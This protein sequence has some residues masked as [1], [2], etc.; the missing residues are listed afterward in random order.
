M[1][2]QRINIRDVDEKA[3][4]AVG[5]LSM[6]LSKG[7]LGEAL[8]AMIEIRAS[9]I[10]NCAWCLDMHTEQ[11]RNA[12]VDQRKLDLL[13]AW[14]EAPAVFTPREQAAMALTEQ[15]TLIAD[16]GVSD[17][18]WDLVSAEFDEKEIVELIM[19]IATIN[20]Y[21]R[22]NVTAHTTVGTERFVPNW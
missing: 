4:K 10:N 22:M 12:G 9:Q 20:V 11:A 2:E 21:N 7:T 8:H 6:Y 16:G 14:S 13:A 18:V 19:S 1:T 5:G 17:E 15:V 3:Y